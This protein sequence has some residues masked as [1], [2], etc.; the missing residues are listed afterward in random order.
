MSVVCEGEIEKSN[1]EVVKQ[2]DERWG[3]TNERKTL[4]FGEMRLTCIP[5]VLDGVSASLVV[6]QVATGYLCA[7]T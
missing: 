5:V 2:Q 6:Q 4:D 1:A 7:N 3:R